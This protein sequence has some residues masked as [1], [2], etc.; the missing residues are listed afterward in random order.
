MKTKN[1]GMKETM[2]LLFE[3][4]PTQSSLMGIKDNTSTRTSLLASG[5]VGNLGGYSH[6]SGGSS[7]LSLA[8][9]KNMRPVVEPRIEPTTIAATASNQNFFQSISQ[10][11]VGRHMAPQRQ[12]AMIE[13]SL[14]GRHVGFREMNY[15]SRERTEAQYIALPE[16]VKQRRQGTAQT[17]SD[18]F[19][20]GRNSFNQ[21]MSLGGKRVYRDGDGRH[22]NES[23]LSIS[24]TEVPMAVLDLSSTMLESEARTPFNKS[25]IVLAW[26][27][28]QAAQTQRNAASKE[29]RQGSTTVTK[30]RGAQQ[31]IKNKSH[32]VEKLLKG[33]PTTATDKK[34]EVD[35][36]LEARRRGS[37]NDTSS[38][39]IRAL[40][41]VNQD[42]DLSLSVKLD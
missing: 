41:F 29:S 28:E 31:K 32:S 17:K 38:D 1:S 34:K 7:V 30:G 10:R 23:T 35:T 14:T 18:I 4:Q 40:H 15:T 12:T 3:K 42:N 8:A 21:T 36:I 24:Q 13:S 26:N 22:K 39:F 5:R 20:T 25:A 9:N 19:N 27:D 33:Y 6:R 11:S 37:R 2:A 16:P